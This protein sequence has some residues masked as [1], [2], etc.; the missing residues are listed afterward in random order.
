M[1]TKNIT[2]EDVHTINRILCYMS[3]AFDIFNINIKKS[4]AYGKYRFDNVYMPYWPYD[5]ANSTVIQVLNRFWLFYIQQYLQELPQEFT[6]LN[7]Y[8]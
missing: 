2:H 8:V 7:I 6:Q 4:I 3:I 5:C 1:S